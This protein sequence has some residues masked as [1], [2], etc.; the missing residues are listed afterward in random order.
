MKFPE[1][2]NELISNLEGLSDL[3][4]QQDCWVN[5]RCP[6]PV[7]YDCFDLPVHFLFD[8]TDLHCDP[9]SLI[10]DILKDKK[11]AELISDVCVAIDNI[12][13]KYGTELSDQEYL[14]LSEWV[15]VLR[16]SKTAFDYFRNTI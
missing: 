14:E 8:D 1:M 16:S 5:G 9:E 13:Q 4:Y 3:R 10:G 15:E 12:F 2:R 6:A 11:E 7:E